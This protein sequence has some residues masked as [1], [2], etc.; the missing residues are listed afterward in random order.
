MAVFSAIAATFNYLVYTG[1]IMVGAGGAGALLAIQA[2]AALLTGAIVYGVGKG[3]GK[4]LMPDFPTG[5]TGLNGGTRV[6][7]APNTGYRVPVVYG[8][9]F[10]N[11][12]ITDAAISS[13]NQTMT[14]VVT[15]SE[16]T[17]GT[18]TLGDLFWNDK[19][20]VF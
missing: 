9:S 16:N 17:T 7:L 14:Y 11:G 19:K 2:G 10:Q 18:T 3:V 5:N 15:F 13:D 12:I 6:Q 4:A 20:L 8:H 1:I